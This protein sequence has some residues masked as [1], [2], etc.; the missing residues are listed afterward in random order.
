VAAALLTQNDAKFQ[1]DTVTVQAAVDVAED[2]LTDEEIAQKVGV[3]RS[4]IT[5]WRRV[6]EF[7]ARV[8]EIVQATAVAMGDLGIASKVRRLEALNERWRTCKRL[9]EMRAE[10]YMDHGYVPAH[11]GLLVQ[12]PTKFG[13]A[14]KFDSALLAELRGIEEQAARELGQWADQQDITLRTEARPYDWGK[15]ST[16][17]LR[18]VEDLLERA[19]VAVEPPALGRGSQS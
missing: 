10:Q 4:T 16:E 8:R 11:T 13:S 9:I 19:L 17:E 12:T 15:L 5:R 6:P 7:R 1:W 14:W 2:R 18:T 3:S